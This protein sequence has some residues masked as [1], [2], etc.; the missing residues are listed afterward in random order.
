M[1]SYLKVDNVIPVFPFLFSLY[2]VLHLCIHNIREISLTQALWASAAALGVAFAF[3]P[4]T[5]LFSVR[6]EKR[7]PLLFLFLLLFHSYG[8]YYEQIAGLLPD[9]LSPLAAHALAVLFPATAW[10]LIHFL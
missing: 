5:R 7:A 4:L 6:P 2:P 9:G 3:W 1:H 10:A 8:L